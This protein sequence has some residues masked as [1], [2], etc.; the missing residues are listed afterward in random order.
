MKKTFSSIPIAVKELKQ[1]KM[2]IVVD[3]PTRENQADLIFPAETATP[4]KVN[5]L[6]QNCRGLICVAITKEQAIRLNLPL[7]VEPI[8]ATETTGVQFT[9]SV[10]AKDV[11]SFGISVS[12]RAKTIKVLADPKAKA[13]DLVRPGH[14]FPLLARD[15]G[16]LVR[17][18]HTE[19]A[20]DLIRL[21]GLFPTAV[22]SEILNERGE[23]ARLPEL[24]KFSK[25]FKIPIVSVGELICY[26]KKHP[27]PCLNTR[28]IFKTASSTLLTKFGLF[29]LSVY[30]SIIDSREHVALF[31]G[32][33]G[34]RIKSP[35]L[36]RIH[37][38][39][40]T[41]ETF[42]SLKCDCQQQLEKSLKLLGKRKQG[43]FIYLNQEGRGIGLTNKI[44]SYS[45]QENGLDTVEANEALGLP[46]DARDYQVAA[47]ILKDLGISKIELL[48]NNPGKIKQLENFGIEV[49]RRIPLECVSKTT[50]IYL[51]VKKSKLGH[52]LKSI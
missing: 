47:E 29:N 4:E 50:K 46:A 8:E 21:A 37:C 48:T 19:A 36:T 42:S 31:K 32:I 45:L 7:M 35:I 25:K 49:T 39:C 20:I 17:P 9:I 16:A 14:I 11:K 30:K 26:L 1:G 33:K 38:Q 24:R 44:K 2:L 10:D 41:G 3:S 27:L 51:Q 40:L 12:D 5:F 15:G 28:I 13:E 43:V 23:I 22:L 18:G 52:L 34:K 6:L